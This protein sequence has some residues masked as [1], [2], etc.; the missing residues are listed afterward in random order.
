[1]GD[2]RV[3]EPPSVRVPVAALERLVEAGADVLKVHEDVLGEEELEPLRTALRAA[4]AALS[5]QQG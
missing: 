5:T 1:M 2:R 3:E 4:R